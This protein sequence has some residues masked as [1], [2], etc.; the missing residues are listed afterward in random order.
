MRQ[1]QQ[2]VTL[3]LK[4]PATGEIRNL[5][6]WDKQEGGGV[7]SEES[8]YTASRGR[9][10]SLG[11]TV[12]VDNVTLSREYELVRDHQQ[13]GWLMALVGRGE[14]TIVK[15]PTDVAFNV[16]GQGLGYIGTLKRCTPPEVDSESDEAGL[17][18][19]EFTVPERPKL[20]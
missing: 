16:N 13:V 8:V 11:G 7:D 5:G 18:E 4:D 10:R 17:L 6:E 9:R 12:T 3:S 20:G 14:G 1:N 15:S 19:L 2:V